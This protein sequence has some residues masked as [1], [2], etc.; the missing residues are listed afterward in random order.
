MS[1][2][3][4]LTGRLPAALAVAVS[5][6]IH[7]AVSNGMQVDEAVCIVVAVAADYARGEYGNKYLK[8]LASVV[9]ERGSI[10]MPERE[11]G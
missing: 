8:D 3:S 7:A 2:K 5:D 10:P 11:D 6:A 1:S 4:R 9:I